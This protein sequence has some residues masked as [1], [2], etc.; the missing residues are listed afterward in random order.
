[1]EQECIKNHFIHQTST[2][3]V[4]QKDK[5]RL[6]AILNQYLVEYQTNLTLPLLEYGIEIEFKKALI[7][8]LNQK[9][10]VKQHTHELNYMIHWLAK[11]ENYSGVD[12]Q[13]YTVGGEIVSPVCASSAED[14]RELA[15]ICNLIEREGGYVDQNCA[16]HIHVDLGILGH[17]KNKWNKLLCLWSIYEDVLIQFGAG[18]T[19]EIRPGFLSYAYPIRKAVQESLIAGNPIWEHEYV[20]EEKRNAINLQYL[21]KYL[22]GE[23][24][25]LQ[26]IEFRIANGTL[27]PIIIQNIIRCY[28]GL[29]KAVK[30][31]NSIL[32][33]YLK[34]HEDILYGIANPECEELQFDMA[35]ELVDIIFDNNQD[36]L[37]FLKQYTGGMVKDSKENKKYQKTL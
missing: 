37:C 2:L 11:E 36:K 14:W 17:D 22:N 19:A 21:N 34:K 30:N 15:E 32:D 3:F 4:L 24:P 20:A 29:L 35:L 23:A 1:M 27:N 13:G 12:E 18:E 28:Y 5:H 33:Y 6:E 9:L 25:D 31:D 16:I 26:T 10:R 7:E 8:I